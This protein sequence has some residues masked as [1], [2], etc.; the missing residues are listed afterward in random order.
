MLF[1]DICMY[2]VIFFLTFNGHKFITFSYLVLPSI[3]KVFTYLRPGIE[4]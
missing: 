4:Q 2:V 1:L 3:N